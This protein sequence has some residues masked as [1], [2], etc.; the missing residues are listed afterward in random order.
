MA[1]IYTDDIRIAH[2]ESCK[3]RAK[4]CD[5]LFG[6]A[7]WAMVLIALTECSELLTEGVFGGLMQGAIGIFAAKLCTVAVTVFSVPAI[8]RRDR[9]MVLGALFGACLCAVTGLFA[10]FGVFSPLFLLMAMVACV[11][12]Q[13]LS[14]EE[15]F[16]QFEITYAEKNDRQRAE[17]VRLSH[18][19]AELSPAHDDIME[20][21]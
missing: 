1:S 18:R 15:G 13:R 9:H 14:R 19:A 2:Y 8:Y 10:M 21:L 4:R 7:M 11:L 16:P 6:I 12:W 3:Q 17:Q 20:E 5:I